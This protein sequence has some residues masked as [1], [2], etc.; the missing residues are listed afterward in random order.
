MALVMSK[1]ALRPVVIRQIKSWAC[2]L[3]TKD[4]WTGCQDHSKGIL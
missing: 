3:T 2:W 4:H 1:V